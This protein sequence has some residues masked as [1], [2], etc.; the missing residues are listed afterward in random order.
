M[1]LFLTGEFFGQGESLEDGARIVA[2]A[3]E[4]VDRGDPG[5]LEKLLDEAGD[6]MA[7]DV[8]AHLLALVAVDF[9]FL[10]LQVAFDQV[11]EKSVQL[12]AG[13]VRPGQASAAQAAGRQAEVEAVF[14]DDN[15]GRRFRRPEKGVLRLVD[16]KILRDAVG[17]SRIVIVPPGFEF[18]EPDEVR[19][20]PVDLVGRHVDE[21]RFRAGAADGLEQIQGADR[22][23]VEVVER[24]GRCAVMAGLR[25]SVDHGIGLKSGQEVEHSLAVADIKF[26]VV[27]VFNQ[28]SQAFLVPA[29]VT[30]RPE[31]HGA[32]VVVETVDFPAEAGKVEANFRADEA[33]GSGDEEFFHG[34][35]G[36]DSLTCP[37][38]RIKAGRPTSALLL[39]GG[40][41]RS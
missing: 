7:V 32:L 21:G 14:L 37:L 3:A 15:V 2:S 23:G 1:D 22:V 12:D 39:R 31:K 6:V 17:I 25:G 34:R 38:P 16:G 9:V 18:L 19:T 33:G 5:G 26:M 30:L 29:C 20:V 36:P 40:R 27:E 8:V 28:R 11:A 24:D 13:V 10:A 35:C 4:V 41:P